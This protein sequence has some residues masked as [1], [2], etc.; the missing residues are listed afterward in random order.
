MGLAVNETK[1]KCMLSIS[2]DLR[3]IRSQEFIYL[4]AAITT[5]SDEMRSSAGSLN[6]YV[7]IVMDSAS[8]G[9]T[10]SVRGIIM[11]KNLQYNAKE[12]LSA[13]LL[14]ST[15]AVKKMSTI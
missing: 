7:C 1:T 15:G 9:Q 11:H 6:N 4:G 13:W 3:H 10:A 14:Y 8:N 5:K 12:V 2:G